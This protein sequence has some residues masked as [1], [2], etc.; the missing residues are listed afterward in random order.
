MKAALVILL[1]LMTA[2]A[3]D[4]KL[5]VKV[6]AS[7]SASAKTVVKLT[8]QNTF[9]ARIESVRATLFL[10]DDQEKVVGQATHWVIGGTK[11]KPALASDTSST[12]NFVIPSD[13]PFAKTKLIVNR[14]V[15]E[16]GKQLDPI[17]NFKV[18]IE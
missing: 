3:A 8:L 13:K 4:A 5:I 17:K 16:G 12:Y 11:D 1:S 9:S 10:F 2:A 18:V 14:I 7:K 15:L 6:G